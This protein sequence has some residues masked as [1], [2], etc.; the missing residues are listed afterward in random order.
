MGSARVS[1]NSKS[2]QVFTQGSASRQ[3]RVSLSLAA[4]ICPSFV[5]ELHAFQHSNSSLEEWGVSPAP[6]AVRRDGLQTAD[7]LSAYALK[8]GR[9]A[10]RSQ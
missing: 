5:V 2:V 7:V 8:C 6:I 10:Q 4:P 9:D 1:Q 3:F